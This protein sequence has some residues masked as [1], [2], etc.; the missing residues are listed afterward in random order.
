MEKGVRAWTTAL[1]ASSDT[2]STRSAMVL[3]VTAA[4]WPRA[5]SR[6]AATLLP[7]GANGPSHSNAA[8]YRVCPITMPS[9]SG[10]R[11]TPSGSGV[12]QLTAGAGA[13]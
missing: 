11:G 8:R 7:S 9:S 2:T 12:T 1:V 13:L 3:G 5:K 6:A 4:N 10:G